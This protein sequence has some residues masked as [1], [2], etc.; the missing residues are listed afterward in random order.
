[1]PDKWG[2]PT[3]DDGLDMALKSMSLKNSMQKN[4]EYGIKK[5][6]REDYNTAMQA[7]ADIDAVTSNGGEAPSM[8]KQY[9]GVLNTPQGIKA[10]K[11]YTDFQSSKIDLKNKQQVQQ[12]AADLREIDE[13][14]AQMFQNSQSGNELLAGIDNWKNL[15][16][17]KRT[18]AQAQYAKYKLGDVETQNAVGEQRAKAAKVYVKN[19]TDGVAAARNM[20]SQ[21]NIDG[22][23][24]AIVNVTKQNNSQYYADINPDN[25]RKLD[26]YFD[27]PYDNEPPKL[28]QTSD[29]NEALKY[30]E[31]ITEEQHA[32]EFFNTQQLAIEF[33]TKNAL[34]PT[35]WKNG[36]NQ[37]DVVKQINPET[38][39]QEF[40]VYS[41][42]EHQVF[43]SI[44]KIR[45][46]YK[47]FKPENLEREKKV[48]D[49]SK[50]EADARLKGSQ[51]D[52]YE[53]NKRTSAAA[54]K[55]E[56]PVSK[57]V[58]ELIK[59]FRSKDD[60][61]DMLSEAEIMGM[62][63]KDPIFKVRYRDILKQIKTGEVNN[64]EKPKPD[65]KKRPSESPTSS[66]LKKQI[67]DAKKGGI[68]I[69]AQRRANGNQRMKN[70]I[71]ELE[72]EENRLNNI[73]LAR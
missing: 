8:K 71:T 46:S 59:D 29:T 64:P 25:P 14:G 51:A 37:I 31:N 49:V 69:A 3:I 50:A 10:S 44:D 36:K 4:E 21:G 68:D 5:Q 57:Q 45:E 18:Q 28:M 73:G 43:G 2:R 17:L 35:V 32:K 40:H 72:E 19:I 52:Y 63:K 60:T 53:A 30:L 65:E 42:N 48:A 27:N 22:A 12:N 7:N 20:Y 55:K 23:N 54:G 11:D 62:I 34:N 15:S 6:D 66:E 9:E 13:I 67:D 61:Y 41:G 38:H 56:D 26:V 16:A 39:A 1:M 24:K 70:R 33:N 58:A 47:G